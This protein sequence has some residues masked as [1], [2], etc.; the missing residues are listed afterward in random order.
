MRYVR[1]AVRSG[2]EGNRDEVVV[3][4]GRELEMSKGGRLVL[5]ALVARLYRIEVVIRAIFS[6]R[7]ERRIEVRV[8]IRSYLLYT[9]P[10]NQD[11]DQNMEKT[12]EWISSATTSSKVSSHATSNT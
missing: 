11:P 7:A 4:R 5:G 1:S 10:V 2:S 9:E 12:Y 8:G 6:F 3:T